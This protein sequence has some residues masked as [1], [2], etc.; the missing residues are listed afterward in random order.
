MRRVN[1][2]PNFTRMNTHIEVTL[3]K[4]GKPFLID[5]KYYINIRFSTQL[6]DYLASMCIQ[7][8][9]LRFKNQKVI[10]AVLL[11]AQTLS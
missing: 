7:Q 3:A 11:N 8:L 4:V 10:N 2:Q 1:A 9:T 5:F 6:F